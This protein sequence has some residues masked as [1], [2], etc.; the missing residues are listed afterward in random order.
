ME[1][2]E[3]ARDAEADGCVFC[4]L[5]EVGDPEGERVLARDDLAFVTLAKYPY[6]PGHLLI[7]PVRHV[8]DVEDLSDEEQASIDRMLR[9][10]LRALRGVA[11]PQGFNV[12]LNIGDAAGAGIPGHLHWHVVPRWRGDTNFMPVVGRTRVLP[13]LLQQTYL[14]L[15]PR[16]DE[17]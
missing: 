15:R 17:T 16:F 12:G 9:R 13:E 2:I 5:L 1:Y 14:K 8:G 10:S 4:V 11:D 6:N 3:V 7:L